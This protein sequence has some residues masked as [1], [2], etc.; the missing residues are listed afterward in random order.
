MKLQH[1][2]GWRCPLSPVFGKAAE[3]QSAHAMLLRMGKYQDRGV[4]RFEWP[5][6]SDVFYSL[7]S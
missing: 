4:L 7:K 6:T 3:P 5:W 1:A 2:C